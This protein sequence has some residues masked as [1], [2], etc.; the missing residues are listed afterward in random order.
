MSDSKDDQIFSDAYE[1]TRKRAISFSATQGI[2]GQSGPS[3]A[4]EFRGPGPGAPISEIWTEQDVIAHSRYSYSTPG[5]EPYYP[6]E[7]ML[8]NV[9]DSLTCPYGCGTVL[10]GVHAFGNLTRHLKTKGCS[11]SSRGKVEHVCQ[12]QVCGKRYSRSDGCK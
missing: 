8:G 5:I 12:V 6:H 4:A 10:T 7:P 3:A 2:L 1:E 11:A 9:N